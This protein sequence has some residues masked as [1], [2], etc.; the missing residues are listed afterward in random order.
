MKLLISFV[1]LRLFY[2]SLYDVFF[3]GRQN[4]IKFFWISPIKLDVDK[5]WKEFLTG[6]S[7]LI[8]VASNHSE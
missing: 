4:Y 7:H 1:E 2:L 5:F 3:M 6:N 8:A